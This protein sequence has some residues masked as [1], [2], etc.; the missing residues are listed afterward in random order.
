MSRILTRM[1][2]LNTS[3]I[4]LIKQKPILRLLATKADGNLAAAVAAVRQDA[5]LKKDPL[6]AELMAS[7][8]Q[9]QAIQDAIAGS[10]R[11]RKAK[12]ASTKAAG[13]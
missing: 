6:I 12:A 11:K 8:D 9:V 7:L 3:D 13:G 1:L 10:P 2:T 5:A 4:A